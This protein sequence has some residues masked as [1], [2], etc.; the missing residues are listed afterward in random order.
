[1]TSLLSKAKTAPTKV[2]ATA[3]RS[4]QPPI[5]PS[6]PSTPC[7]DP[8][9]VVDSSDSIDAAAPTPKKRVAHPLKRPLDPVESSVPVV[10]CKKKAAPVHVPESKEP[11]AVVSMASPRR[12]LRNKGRSNESM[13]SIELNEPKEPMEPTE[14][15]ELSSGS[16][17]R[18]EVIV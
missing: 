1:M 3:K 12:S 8:G 18:K 2:V 7:I 10:P 17:V 5:T 13:E 6:N 16:K 11:V 9:L 15:R 4:L 14:S